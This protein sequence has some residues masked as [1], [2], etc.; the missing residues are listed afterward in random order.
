MSGIEEEEL[1]HRVDAVLAAEPGVVHV[2][3]ARPVVR[4]ALHAATAETTCSWVQ[5]GSEL[6][7]TAS[8]GV[9]SSEGG[10][11]VAGR[12]AAAVRGI[13]GLEEAVVRIRVSR[14]VPADEGPSGVVIM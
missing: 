1:A 7:V 4:H 6:R 3:P 13:P 8:V 9:G 2:Y 14:I 12:L 11:A 10:A 5:R